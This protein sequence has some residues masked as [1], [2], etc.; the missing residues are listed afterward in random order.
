[1]GTPS[2]K[3]KLGKGNATIFVASARE[4]RRPRRPLGLTARRIMNE[5]KK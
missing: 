1:M 4:G 5:N 2:L 3:E